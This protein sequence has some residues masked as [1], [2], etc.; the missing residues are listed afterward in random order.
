M[1]RISVAEP[2]IGLRELWHV[3]RSIK[4]KQ[5]SGYSNESIPKF[6]EEF[7]LYSD[8]KYA[9]AVSNG[10]TAIYLVLAT[11]GIGRG[12]EV[13]VSA[14]TNMASFF[15]VLQ[16]GAIPIPV[17]VDK[18]HFNMDPV[19]LESKITSTTRAIIVVHIFGHP[20]PMTE[21]CLIAEKYNLV[22]IED[23]AEAHGA[24]INGKRVGSFGLAGCF[25]F[26]ANKLLTT[27]EGGMITTS[28]L[29]LRN[30][31]NSIASLSFGEKN[32]FLH[33]RDGYNFRLSNIQA[34]FGLAQMKR[35]E[36]TITRKQKIAS[37]YSSILSN[38]SRLNLPFSEPGVRNVVWMYLVQVINSE[39]YPVKLIIE[40]LQKLGVECREGFIPFSDQKYVLAQYNLKPVS[41]PIASKAGI[42]TF[43]LP[44]G[45]RLSKRKIKFVCR[46]LSQVLDEL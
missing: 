29:E 2:V 31:L 4:R 44:S 45:P 19:D 21:I 30:N 34:A 3:L 43:Y 8:S 15:P 26:Y 37:I 25:S 5:I 35:I 9:V 17:D 42:S 12:D 22:I 46:A 39:R 32:K 1:K 10:T 24:E 16:L 7:A 6:E 13:L 27:G 20:A 38:D 41:T 11:L 23:C 14:Y 18:D 33:K 28:N 40:K 36:K